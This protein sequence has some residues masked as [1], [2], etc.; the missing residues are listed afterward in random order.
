MKLLAVLVCFAL[1]PLAGLAQN[2]ESGAQVPSAEIRDLDLIEAELNKSASRPR[3]ESQQRTSPAPMDTQVE[4]LS[5]LVQLAPFSEVS[6]LQKRFQPKTGRFQLFGG[7]TY[8]ANDPWF[9]GGGGNLRFGYG[10]TEAFGVEAS[11]YGVGPARKDAVNDLANNHRVDT[12]S[13]VT[14]RG[15]MG[16]QLV[17]TPIYGK[18]GLFNREIV[19]FDMYFYLGGGNSQLSGGSSGSAGTFVAG[20]GQIFAFSK[21]HSLRW[22]LGAHVFQATSEGSRQTFTN[23]LLSVGWSWFFP[24]V[25]YR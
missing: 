1:F 9:W 19:P 18:M 7:L 3:P 5:D 4:R 13:L 15:Y 2:S 23:V 10:F 24:E 6:V 16:G 21:S 8:L 12:S 25:R 11:L 17:W 14:L 22:D 20:T